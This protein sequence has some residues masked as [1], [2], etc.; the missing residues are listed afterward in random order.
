MR[1]VSGAFWGDTFGVETYQEDDRDVQEEGNETVQEQREQANVVDLVHG[2]LG[3]FPDQS[4]AEVHDRAD[5]RKVVQRDQRVHLVLGRAKQTLH[6]GKA[7]GLEDDSSDL[8]HESDHD[9]LD[10]ANRSDDHTNDNRGDVEEHLQVGLRHSHAPAAKKDG[11][12]RGSLEHLDEGDAQVEVG[13]VATD[14]AQTEEETDGDDGPQVDPPRHLD[15]L[16][17]IE[18]RCIA[19]QQLCHERRE[20]QVVARQD[21]RVV[22]ESHIVSQTRPA[23]VSEGSA[24]CNLRN[25]RVS[26]IHLLNKM[27][28]E[29]MEIQT[30]HAIAH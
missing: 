21:N 27:T 28:E 30:L 22:Y 16:A 7:D 18:E 10:L 14:Q 24:A 17:P 6:H 25:W 29:L 23:Q 9:E 5:R 20:S 13:Q 1:G 4:N 3:D 2:Y 12:G 19:S 11:N 8:E 15:R 26:R